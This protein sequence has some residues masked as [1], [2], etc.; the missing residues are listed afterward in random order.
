MSTFDPKKNINFLNLTI[1]DLIQFGFER[2][3]F[4]KII[5]KKHKLN[6]YVGKVLSIGSGRALIEVNN[7]RLVIDFENLR[8]YDLKTQNKQA[9]AGRLS[10][11]R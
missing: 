11:G 10:Y 5:D 3:D 4:V 1:F 9:V 2:N 6:G 8:S 7:K